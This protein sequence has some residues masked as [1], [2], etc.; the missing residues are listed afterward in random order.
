MSS[1]MKVGRLQILSNKAL[2]LVKF[3]LPSKFTAERGVIS[4][5][6]LLQ[7]TTRPS[8]ETRGAGLAFCL[9]SST[10]NTRPDPKDLP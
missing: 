4:A 1:L 3:S 10:A 5:T 2:L 9:I 6:R 7:S 8:A